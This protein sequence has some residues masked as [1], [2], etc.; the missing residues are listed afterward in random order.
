VLEIEIA[1]YN[2]MSELLGLF[3]PALL[4]EHP[5]HRDEKVLKL[6]PLQYTGFKETTSYYLK[7]LNAFDHICG[8]TDEYATELYKKLKGIEIPQHK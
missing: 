5:N 2:V 3:V 4:K 1:G 6:F 7:V 8:M